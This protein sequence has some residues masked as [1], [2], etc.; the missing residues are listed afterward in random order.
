M[1]AAQTTEPVAVSLAGAWSSSMEWPTCMRLSC[2]CW[3][4]L[5]VLISLRL[6][7]RTG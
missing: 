3:R 7:L 1:V 2:L 6:V 5:L 4:A